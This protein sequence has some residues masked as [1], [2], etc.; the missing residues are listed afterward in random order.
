MW[1]SW[2]KSAKDSKSFKIF[3]S[4][5]M[6]VYKVDDLEKTD[7]KI[8]ELVNKNYSTIVVTNEIAGFSGDIIKKYRKSQNVNIIIAPNR[9]KIE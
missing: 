6:D 7:A 2:L 3:E 8:N 9:N 5:G 4:F 1:I